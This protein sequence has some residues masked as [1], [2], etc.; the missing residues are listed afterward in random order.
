MLNYRFLNFMSLLEGTSL[1]ALLFIAMPLKYSFGMPE[2]VKFVGMT[3][4]ILFIAF[5]VVL[6]AFVG[7]KKLSEMQGFKGFIASFIPFGTFI[8]SA[9]VVRK[10]ME[11]ETVIDDQAFETKAAE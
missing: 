11:Q 6:F 1:I 4:G 10:K 9:M 5:N 2:A 8:F 7:A 3:H